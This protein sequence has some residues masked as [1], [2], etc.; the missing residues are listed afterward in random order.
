MTD[1]TIRTIFTCCATL[2][3]VVITQLFTYLNSKGD[4]TDSIYKQQYDKI[5]FAYS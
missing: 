1:E 5:F 2:G 3:A 4:K